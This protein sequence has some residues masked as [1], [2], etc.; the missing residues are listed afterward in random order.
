LS[1]LGFTRE[2]SIAAL[3]ALTNGFLTEVSIPADGGGHL[4]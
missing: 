2:P 1:P 4:V 3:T